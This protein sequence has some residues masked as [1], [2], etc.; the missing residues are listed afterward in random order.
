MPKYE[1][2]EVRFWRRVEKS[3]GCWLWTGHR[4]RDGYGM[5]GLERSG[6]IERTHR[7]SWIFANG[8]IP[9]G[10]SVLHRCD[11]PA[12]VRPDH[13]FIGTQADNIHD[14]DA[15]GRARKNPRRGEAVHWTKLK[16]EDI[17]V[18]RSLSADGLNNTQ[19]GKR[20]GVHRLTI[21]L[22]LNGKNWSHV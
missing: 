10:M 20:F 19:I 17:P 14:M 18:I 16:A 8:P 6:G 1:P 21:H 22:I 11:M 4:N 7:L 13:L 15:K 12:C 9:A 2:L 5:I 3:D